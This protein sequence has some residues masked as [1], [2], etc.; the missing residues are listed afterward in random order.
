MHMVPACSSPQPQTAS[1]SSNFDFD[2]D[3]LPVDCQG[4][5]SLDLPLFHEY[6]LANAC[7]AAATAN[8]KPAQHAPLSREYQVPSPTNILSPIEVGQ[9]HSPTMF[10]HFEGQKSPGSAKDA[11]Q[12]H[13]GHGRYGALPSPGGASLPPNSPYSPA[14]RPNRMSS[15]DSCMTSAST[16]STVSTSGPGGFLLQDSL[17]EF[18]E[19]QARIKMEQVDVMSPPPAYATAVSATN[20]ANANASSASG[21]NMATVKI[22]PLD[23]SVPEQEANKSFAMGFEV[24]TERQEENEGSKGDSDVISMAMESVR[25]DIEATCKLLNISYGEYEYEY[26]ILLSPFQYLS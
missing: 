9:A 13:H 17:A 1:A 11:A 8:A 12:Q 22:E 23:Q 24:K 14:M 20:N 18:Q 25:K 5:P 19:L 26:F 2:L 7:A 4:V 21:S 10:G 16:T 15:T 3:L 6:G